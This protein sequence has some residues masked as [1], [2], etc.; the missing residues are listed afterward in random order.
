MLV[1]SS[2]L[3][4]IMLDLLHDSIHQLNTLNETATMTFNLTE[5]PWIN[6]GRQYSVR[7]SK[8]GRRVA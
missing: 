4:Q 5:S 2:D 7:V 1:S 6:A 8:M 3:H